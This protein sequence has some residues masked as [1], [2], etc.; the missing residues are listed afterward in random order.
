MVWCV[1]EKD[2]EGGREKAEEVQ[3]GGE[4]VKLKEGLVVV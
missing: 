1:G 3:G 4:M 2:K